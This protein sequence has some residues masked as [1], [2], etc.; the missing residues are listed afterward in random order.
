VNQV[1]D[2]ANFQAK[3]VE[4]KRFIALSVVADFVRQ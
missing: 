4:F 3:Q 2:V 1:Q